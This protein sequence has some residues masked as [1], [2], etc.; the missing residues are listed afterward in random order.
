[1]FS[2]V[3]IV[4]DKYCPNVY[5]HFGFTSLNSDYFIRVAVG[6]GKLFWFFS[7][8]YER[9]KKPNVLD[10]VVAFWYETQR[11]AAKRSWRFSPQMFIRS[12]NVC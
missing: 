9:W 4:L 10:R 5:K 1:M 6:K 12:T 7:V 11:F 8:G 3:K 2:L